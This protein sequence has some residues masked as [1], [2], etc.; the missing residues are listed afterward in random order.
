MAYQ[1]LKPFASYQAGD[2]AHRRD[3]WWTDV[4]ALVA[5]GFLRPV[6]E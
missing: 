6:T 2:V 3:L 4:E 5:N 1:V